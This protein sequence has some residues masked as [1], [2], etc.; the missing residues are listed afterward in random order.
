MDFVLGLPQSHG[1]K[2]SIFVVVDRFSKMAHFIA[3]SKT[4]DATHIADLFFKE[5][6][7]LHGLPKIIVSDR[8]V[9]FSSHFW[10]ILCNKL[11]TKVLFSIVAHP[12]TDGQIEVVNKT[13]TTLLLAI[14][15]KNLENWEKCLPHVEFAYN[16]SVH[17]TTSYSSFKVVYGFNPMTPLDILPLPCLLMSMLI[18]MVRK[19]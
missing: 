18:L 5:V 9:K 14:I 16:R 2:D 7:H 11:G 17:S 15:Q 13:L 4:N 6:M 10:R 8:D 19:R 3:C 1:G 12:Q